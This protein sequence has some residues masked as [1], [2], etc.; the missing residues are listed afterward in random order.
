MLNVL[1]PLCELKNR[2]MGRLSGKSICFFQEDY[3]YFKWFN[4]FVAYLDVQSTGFIKRQYLIKRKSNFTTDF[5]NVFQ[6]YIV[7]NWGASYIY[8]FYQYFD[9]ITISQSLYKIRRVMFYEDLSN[10]NKMHYIIIKS[11]SLDIVGLI[12]NKSL[13]IPR[14]RWKRSLG[15]AGF[16]GKNPFSRL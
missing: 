3:H 4:N 12:L 15:L 5:W 2:K 14:K 6:I 9:A 11:K 8:I 16:S 10:K 1:F 13:F 7:G